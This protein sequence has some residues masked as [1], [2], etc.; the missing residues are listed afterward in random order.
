MRGICKG[1]TIFRLWMT[2]VSFRG[3]AGLLKCDDAELLHGSRLLGTK[4]AGALRLDVLETTHLHNLAH[5]SGLSCLEEPDP[6]LLA[7][8]APALLA[9]L[10][11]ERAC[12]RARQARRYRCLES[13]GSRARGGSPH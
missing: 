8:R 12:N 2:W 13:F 5:R 1:R 11:G 10:G 3:E 9:A 4:T 6:E 7:P